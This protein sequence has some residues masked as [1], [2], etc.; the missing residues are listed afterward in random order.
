[1][2]DHLINAASNVVMQSLHGT[3]MGP[4]M[5]SEMF[6]ELTMSRMHV[7]TWKVANGTKL[8]GNLA[9]GMFAEIQPGNASYSVLTVKVLP[10]FPNITINSFPEVCTS[11]EELNPHWK[12]ATIC[13]KIVPIGTAAESGDLIFESEVQPIDGSHGLRVTVKS[14]TVFENKAFTV[15][16]EANI[17]SKFLYSKTLTETRETAAGT[18]SLPT[19]GAN[20]VSKTTQQVTPK[21]FETVLRKL[22]NNNT[23]SLSSGR[24]YIEGV[25][26][27]ITE[28]WSATELEADEGLL[29]IDSA[30]ESFGSG[31]VRT[32][33][34]ADVPTEWPVFRGSTIEDK[35]NISVEFNEQYVAHP[36]LV[37]DDP[38]VAYTPVNADRVLKRTVIV[39]TTAIEAIHET[40]PVK[41]NPVIPK[42]LRGVTVVWNDTIQ[43]GDQDSVWSG[44]ASGTNTSLSCNLSD[45]STSEASA[46]PEFIPDIDEWLFNDLPGTGHLFYLASPVSEAAILA[47]L[48]VGVTRWPVFRPKSHT[49][50]GVGR[51]AT[52]TAQVSLNSSKSL[53]PGNSSADGGKTESISK[54]VGATNVVVTLP[55]TIHALVTLDG[56]TDK[57]VTASAAAAINCTGDIPTIAASAS[58]VVDLLA[59]VTPT[60]LPATE[61]PTDVPT[62]G[63]YLLDVNVSPYKWGYYQIYA[64]T[65]DASV[66]APP[67]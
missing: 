61:G 25:K 34:A 41:V 19:L 59:F 54:S 38:T 16:R 44:T 53:S 1:M 24:T 57:A 21:T 49:L 52:C 60:E 32:T 10:G 5:H 56:D 63:I 8:T 17:P 62:S 2:S 39:P 43:D 35:L 37:D 45:S 20:E 29:V 14:F 40:F 3:V 36:V 22:S 12:N 51:R 30:V 65:F 23:E 27:T 33:I 18:A 4:V 13:R 11:S 50:V 42:V 9:F 47:K 66:L 28:T 15:Q 6:D 31:Y 26:A 46:L 48:G 55:P 58:D 7:L 67:P 64:E